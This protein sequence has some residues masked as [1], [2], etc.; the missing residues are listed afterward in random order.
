MAIRRSQNWVNQQ[1]VD[2]PHLRSIESAVRNDFD[3]LLSSLVLGEDQSYVLRGFEISMSGAI[4]SAASSLQLLVEEGS[5]FHGKSAEA[6]T[7]FVVPS[8]TAPEVLSSTTNEKIEGSFTPSALN[9]VGIEYTREVDDSTTAQLFLWNPTTKN[10]IS[11]T[12]P[13]ALTFDYKVVIT[14]SIFASNVLP[15]AIVETDASNNVLSVEDRRPMLFRV[16]TAG[17][18]TPDPYYKYP[19]T[20]GRS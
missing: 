6:G 19:W 9:Y 15:I 11:K 20:E 12:A 16:A 13:L 10:E 2:I 3:E 5:I 8:G 1:R 18:N 4:G 14:S 17:L 7:F